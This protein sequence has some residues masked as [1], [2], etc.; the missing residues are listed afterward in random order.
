MSNV[1]SLPKRERQQCEGTTKAGR[2][3]SFNAPEGMRH[4]KLHS[5]DEEP[6]AVEEHVK[7]MSMAE[8]LKAAEQQIMDLVPIAMQALVDVL[9]GEDTKPADRIKAA[10][11]V[12]DRSVAQRIQVENVTSDTRDLDV[13]IEEALAEV[14]D[15]L[16]TGTDG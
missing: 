7:K 10:Q 16:R 2:R 5:S 9:T 13:E 12:I 1:F 15:E 14:R 11:M 4:C 3:C 8:Q 6:V